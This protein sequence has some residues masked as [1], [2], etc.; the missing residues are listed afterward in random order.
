MPQPPASACSSDCRHAPHQHSLQCILP[1][2]MIEAL[3]LRGDAKIRK[4]C[5]TLEREAIDARASRQQATPPG[6]FLAAPELEDGIP[7][8]PIREIFDG[9]QRATLPG[10]P[11]RSEDEEPTDDEDV[12]LAFDGAGA[13]YKLL[14]EV[15]N[16]DSLDGRG[17]PLIST[18]HH[19]RAYNNA[20]WDGRQMA[21][22]DGDGFLFLPL[23]RSLTVIGHELAH[24]V[25]QFSGG[26]VYQ[27]Q[28]GALN[29]SFADVFGSLTMQYAKNQI[30]AEADWRIGG[31]IL[32]PDIQ[33]VALRSLKVP[34]MAYDDP[35]LGKDPQPFHME[36]Y[37]N[38]AN[39]NGGVHLNSGIPNHAFYLLAQYLGGFAW[40]KAGWIWYDTLQRI[41]NPHAGFSD[42][43][44][45]TIEMARERF[46]VGSLE[47]QLTRR[48][49]KLVGVS[50]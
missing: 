7:P 30:A 29:E 16:R 36:G 21:Y 8:T 43:A 9:K 12:N 49:W 37:V 10:T 18:V 17:M 27:D 24:G 26:L 11:V 5:D 34:G 3:R 48:A 6:A 44:D 32:G 25:V 47:A 4:M 23:T 33:G 15:Y 1:P 41:S 13:T 45:K 19:R 22:G 42:W 14:L 39:D 50:V 28:S 38:T 20:F 46:G 2:H 31:E 35:L 40:E